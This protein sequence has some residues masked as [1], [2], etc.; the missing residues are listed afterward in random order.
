[1]T[2]G[3]VRPAGWSST[4]PS[5]LHLAEHVIACQQNTSRRVRAASDLLHPDLVPLY[6]RPSP[7]CPTQT[8]Q[9]KASSTASSRLLQR[10]SVPSSS[11]LLSPLRRVG[12]RF[13]PQLHHQKHPGTGGTRGRSPES[14]SIAMSSLALSLRRFRS[15]TNP[16]CLRY[17]CT[18][19]TVLAEANPLPA[20]L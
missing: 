19:L 6:G 17:S 15:K 1:M 14:P 18:A 10:T 7:L 9:P 11:A 2:T 12:P 13:T 16:V 4:A 20:L 5:K 8:L 3:P